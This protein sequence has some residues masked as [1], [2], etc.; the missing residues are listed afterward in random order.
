M[1][2]LKNKSTVFFLCNIIV[3]KLLNPVNQVSMKKM[4]N[5]CEENTV[6]SPAPS[7][8][9]AKPE[10]RLAAGTRLPVLLARSNAVEHKPR[11]IRPREIEIG[12]SFLIFP[13]DI[14]NIT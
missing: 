13:I 3:L 14:R 6:L 9:A 12:R 4:S 7:G 10:E 11:D 1:P 5:A 8:M 2:L